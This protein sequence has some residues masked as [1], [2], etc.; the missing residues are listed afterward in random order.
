MRPTKMPVTVAKEMEMA[1]NEA[2]EDSASLAAR[3]NM[4]GALDK[5]KDAVK[6]ERALVRY[7]EVRAEGV[8]VTWR[9]SV[10]WCGTSR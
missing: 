4:A 3:G 1:V 5:A 7:L 8:G 6:K 2:L 10:R 9:R